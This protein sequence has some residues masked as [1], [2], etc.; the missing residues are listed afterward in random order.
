MKI[1]KCAVSVAVAVALTPASIARELT[2]E[3]Y[4]NEAKQCPGRT[5][6][7]FPN[8]TIFIC[9]HGL[10]YYIITKP[11]HPAYPGV[12]IRKL[13]DGDGGTYMDTEG[14]SFGADA[15][16]PAFKAWMDHFQN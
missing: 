1:W 4:V 11:N 16:Q 13:V 2:F 3:D 9:D 7:D 8:H 14:H 15:D 6:K 5:T 10:T 12:I